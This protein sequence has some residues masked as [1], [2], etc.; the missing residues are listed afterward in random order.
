MRLLLTLALVIASGTAGADPRIELVVNGGADQVLFG[1]LGFA[2]DGALYVAGTFFQKATLGGKQLRAARRDHRDGF[3]ARLDRTGKVVWL[4][5]AGG[6]SDI[7]ALAVAPNGDVVIGGQHEYYLG[8][9]DGPATDWRSRAAVVRFDAKGKRRWQR[10]FPT[11][12]RSRIGDLAVADDG[13]VI[14]VGYYADKTTFGVQALD[15]IAVKN[16]WGVTLPSFD[17]FVTRLRAADG[18]VDWVATGGGGERDT[19]ESVAITPKGDIVIAGTFGPAAKFGTFALTGPAPFPQQQRLTNPSWSYVARYAGTGVLKWAVQVQGHDDAYVK[20]DAV[21]ALED[22]AVLVYA[23]H[24][25]IGGKPGDHMIAH[26][27][28]AHVR[29]DGALATR[30]V[31]E[32]DAVTGTGTAMVAA[33][34]TVD[35]LVFEEHGPAN[36]ARKTLVTRRPDQ[37]PG[38]ARKMGRYEL[39]PYVL[40]RAADG[41]YAMASLAGAMTPSSTS[42]LGINFG[43]ITPVIVISKTLADLLPSKSR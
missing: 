6:L 21:V 9:Q 37:T 30:A 27:W 22:E 39:T 8:K 11:F 18:T 25:A 7:S 24:R 34:V 26:P 20:S 12:D 31:D 4:V 29:P 16:P 2:D 35:A 14:A 42:P 36:S 5:R 33:R 1:G 43:S 32:A 17:A 41:R 19:A 3:V 38:T 28:V 10:E 40:V 13:A 15:S 23:N